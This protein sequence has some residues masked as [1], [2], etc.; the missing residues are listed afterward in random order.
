[1][2]EY[3]A[4]FQGLF[5][6]IVTNVLLEQPSDLKSYILKFVESVQAGQPLEIK[7][8]VASS[9]L[10]SPEVEFRHW[11]EQMKTYMHNC[12]SVFEF[13]FTELAINQP[14]NPTA[15]IVKLLQ[16][17][18]SREQKVHTPRGPNSGRSPRAVAV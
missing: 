15:F 13:I 10:L 5:E 6:Q 9:T 7:G 3:T 18:I 8:G 12:H 2:R 16:D 14:Q 1:M 11:G 4:R 17:E